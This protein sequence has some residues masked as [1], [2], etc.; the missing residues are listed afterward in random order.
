MRLRMGIAIGLVCATAFCASAQMRRG[1]FVNLVGDTDDAI[2]TAKIIKDVLWMDPAARRAV[3]QAREAV[4]QGW[5]E[6]RSSA[7]LTDQER[8]IIR[9]PDLFDQPLLATVNVA[10]A[11]S[12]ITIALEW[13]VPPRLWS[14]LATA[15]TL[16]ANRVAREASLASRKGL[17]L[18][19]K[20]QGAEL[21]RVNTDAEGN[22][23]IVFQYE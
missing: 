13:D 15:V 1:D 19:V 5:I 10:F 3:L 7:L 21:Y 2:R 6:E 22:V 23:A 9:N 17:R 14:R 4:I 8:A 18:V 20:F 16:V 11:A 12:P